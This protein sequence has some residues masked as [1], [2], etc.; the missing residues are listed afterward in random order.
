MDLLLETEEQLEDY[1][2]PSIPLE[3]EDLS[4]MEDVE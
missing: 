1:M 3:V 2:D 4:K